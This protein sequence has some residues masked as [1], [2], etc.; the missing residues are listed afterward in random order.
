MV[1]IF[2]NVQKTIT[3]K[4]VI[5]GA[6][7]A[8]TNAVRYNVLNSEDKRILSGVANNDG[9]G[10]WSAAITIPESYNLPQNATAE[11]LLVEFYA[12]DVN[13]VERSRDVYLNLIDS[14]D[15]FVP[16]G[17][18]G[19]INHTTPIYDYLLVSRPP[20]ANES[21]QTTIS[22]VGGNNYYSDNLTTSSFTK[23]RGATD[24]PDRFEGPSGSTGYLWK[25]EMPDLNGLPES[26]MPY[27]VMYDINGETY[28]HS[29]YW[30]NRRM[31]SMLNNMKVYLDK[32]NLKEIDPT[33]QWH[34]AELVNS[35]YHGLQAVNA[36]PNDLTFWKFS[37]FP[38]Q[39]NVYW[40]YSALIHALNTRYLAEGMNAFEFQGLS[41]SLTYDRKEALSYKIEEL[42]GF[43]ENLRQAKI[44][45][46]RTA[47][48]G[49]QDTTLGINQGNGGYRVGIMHL[50]L[51]PLNNHRGSQ[52][53][54]ANRHQRMLNRN[55]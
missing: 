18:V 45:A 4:F 23:V 3:T 21:V 54:T 16:E 2:K 28:M 40:E 14:S 1:E 33:L 53:A 31:L 39:L 10:L 17:I 19:F 9:N 51:N 25:L 38:L 43:L 29:L 30:V 22:S 11:E 32:A 26:T 6:P 52:G 50:T 44:S 13:G 27:Q 47:G 34:D 49:T 12:K 15:D 5:V 20:A 8:F 24:V 37:D 55:F 35:I 48:I 7:I 36:F 46:V 42:K 41:T